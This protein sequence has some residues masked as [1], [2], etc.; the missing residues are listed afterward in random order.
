MKGPVSTYLTL[1]PNLVAYLA[2]YNPRQSFRS[3]L[4]IALCGVTFL[5]TMSSDLQSIVAEIQLN[6]YLSSKSVHT[7]DELVLTPHY[8]HDRHCSRVRL[9]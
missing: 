9:Q 5:E 4:R 8:S 7:C 1:L 6:N 3:L 2:K